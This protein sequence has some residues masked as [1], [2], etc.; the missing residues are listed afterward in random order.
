MKI[1]IYKAILNDDD[2][3]MDFNSWVDAPAHSKSFE[4]F[5]RNEKK[6]HAF[7]DNE[8]MIVSGVAIATDVP[9]YRNSPDMGEF[10]VYF[11][12]EQ[13][14]RIAEKM[15]ANGFLHNVNKMHD[16]GDV[17]DRSKV[18]LVESY[19]IDY[20]RGVTPPKA[21]ANQN[22]KDGS[23]II[24][25]KVNDKETW[26]ELKS[27]KFKGFSIEVWMSIQKT[28]FKKQ[29]KKQNNMKENKVSFLQHIRNFFNEE[30]VQTAEIETKLAEAVTTDGATIVWDGEMGEGTE[31]RMIDGEG[32]EILAPEGVHS[33]TNESGREVVITIDANGIVTTY[34]ELEVMEENADEVAEAIEELAKENAELTKQVEDF[35]AKFET[36]KAEIEALK[37]EL[38][39][40]PAKPNPTK[41]KTEFNLTNFL[42]KH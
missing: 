4:L 30:E 7:F 10:Y 24:S 41:T 12:K 14:F 42:K 33:Y 2:E 31:V 11:D 16:G 5:G 1:P 8:R 28:N 20:D 13:T 15:M 27:G 6:K 34:E 17:V 21:M 23:W 3:G 37:N 19:F 22:L 38:D 25:Y 40:A 35:K 32:N 18:T 36:A 9:I 26:E 39:K 29:T